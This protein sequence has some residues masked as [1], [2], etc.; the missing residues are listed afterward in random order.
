MGQEINTPRPII[1]A[2]SACVWRGDEVLLVQRGNVHG[3]GFWSLPGGKIEP[4]ET[5]IEAAARELL[6]ETGCL[7]D[8]AQQVG[9]FDL[10]GES[11]H[12]VISCFAGHHAGGEAVAGA[13]AMAV[14]WVNHQNIPGFRLAPNTADAIARAR[15]L[16][17]S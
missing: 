7:A 5:A 13:D 10:A 8:L 12:Y 14:A 9:D 16:L 15:Q 6:E 1:K 3:Y 17:T 2:A 4:G 11:A